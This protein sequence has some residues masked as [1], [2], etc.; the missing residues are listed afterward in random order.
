MTRKPRIWYPK[1]TYHIMGRGVRQQNIF[2]EPDDYSIFLVYLK[3]SLK[4]YNCTLH[5]YCLMTNHIH[6][7]VETNDIPISKFVKHLFNCYAQYYNRK[8]SFHGHLFEGRYKSGLIQNDSYFLQTS[9]YI[10]LNPVK[11][12]MVSAPQDYLW[13]S[14]SVL[15]GK[16]KDSITSISKTLSFF[17]ED[18]ISNY[19]HFVESSTEKYLSSEQKIQTEMGE[20]WKLVSGT[21]QF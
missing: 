18:S 4:K 12:T 10:H 2:T 19:R 17:E 21:N 14:Y 6:L 11:A 15:I 16:T 5:A 7:L 3:H 1:S 8:Y 9:R 20:S 13:S